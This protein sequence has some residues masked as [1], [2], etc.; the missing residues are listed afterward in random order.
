ME[1]DF[2]FGTG[3]GP[4]RRFLELGAAF[5]AR[6]S[7]PVTTYHL[8]SPKPEEQNV[9]QILDTEE[10]RERYQGAPI[11]RELFPPLGLRGQD[12]IRVILCDGPHLLAWLG[13]YRLDPF[14]EKE[15]GRRRPR[16]RGRPRPLR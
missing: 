6:H 2:A 7:G 15:A 4:R 12:Q 14:G 3:I 8:P 13:A 1:V 5:F 9:V 16:E 11:V 10:A